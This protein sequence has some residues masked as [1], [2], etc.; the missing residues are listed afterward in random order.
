MCFTYRVKEE[1]E[2]IETIVISICT[3][4]PFPLFPLDVSNVLN[5]SI[6][7]RSPFSLLV[8]NRGELTTGTN[9]I[10]RKRMFVYLGFKWRLMNEERFS[11]LLMKAKLRFQ[12][13]TKRVNFFV[14]GKVSLAE[15]IVSA[16]LICYTRG[17]QLRVF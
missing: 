16:W 14:Y 13:C 10:V 5:T 12:S 1:Q 4:I 3:N 2:K 17:R 15:H 6:I 9:V 8:Q 11:K 7:D